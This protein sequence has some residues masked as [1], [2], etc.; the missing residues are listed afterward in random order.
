[1]NGLKGGWP[2]SLINDG[3][4]TNNERIVIY[5]FNTGVFYD[6][7]SK[8]FYKQKTLNIKIKMKRKIATAEMLRKKTYK[9]R[10]HKCKD[11]N[12]VDGLKI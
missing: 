9:P 3:N 2:L 11:V 7:K 4:E 10:G 6:H 12:V 8:K 1:M 5:K